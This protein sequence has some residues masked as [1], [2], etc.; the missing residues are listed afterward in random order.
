MNNNDGKTP[1]YRILNYLDTNMAAGKC[2]AKFNWG[3]L[4][5]I[6]VI[7][8]RRRTPFYHTVT[9]RDCSWVEGSQSPHTIQKSAWFTEVFGHNPRTL[10]TAR[11]TDRHMDLR[12]HRP[13]VESR[14]NS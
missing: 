6:R 11:R 14:P 10:Q 4:P 13:D 5:P 8:G 12:W 1:V 7:G 3:Q 2:H 9:V